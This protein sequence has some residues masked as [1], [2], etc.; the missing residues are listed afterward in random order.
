MVGSASSV[1]GS[2][3]GKV[4]SGVSR[5]SGVGKVSSGVSRVSGVGKSTTGYEENDPEVDHFALGKNGG[6]IMK[7][8]SP[9]QI[10]MQIAMSKG[11]RKVNHVRPRIV[12][13]PIPSGG[14]IPGPCAAVIGGERRKQR[15]SLIDADVLQAASGIR[16]AATAIQGTIFRDVE[17]FDPK[18]AVTD[19][20]GS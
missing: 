19:I 3:V 20:L 16:G 18:K 10:D 4:S 13:G 11:I 14:I 6:C 7:S 9:L 12:E 1:V 15:L 5:V 17:P 2:V 8:L